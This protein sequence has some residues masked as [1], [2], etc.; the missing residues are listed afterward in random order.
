MGARDL[1]RGGV[2]LGVAI[3]LGG[4]E[5]TQGTP[6]VDAG[7]DAYDEVDFGPSDAPRDTSPIDIGIYDAPVVTDGGGNC[8]VYQP[9]GALVAI[10]CEPGT[11]C[12]VSGLV[13]MCAR[14][15]DAGL[16]CGNIQC[17]GG[18]ACG[19]DGGPPCI[20]QVDQ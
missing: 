12:D 6:I 13:P 7:G 14:N 8:W 11:T 2:L 16:W 17:A 20:G 1:A 19:P 15:E 18:F 4:C 10:E 3:V 9:S 5:P